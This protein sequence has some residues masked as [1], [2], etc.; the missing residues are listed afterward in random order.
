[1]IQ[2]ITS[3]PAISK[4]NSFVYENHK[5]VMMHITLDQDALETYSILA[6]KSTVVI[7]LYY[8]LLDI[9]DSLKAFKLHPINKASATYED[10]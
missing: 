4:A 7:E 10:S 2:R 1:M 9:H 6:W 3:Q 5:C 8:Q